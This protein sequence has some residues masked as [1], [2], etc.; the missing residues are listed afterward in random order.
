M[1][2]VELIKKKSQL[3]W[4]SRY[5]ICIDE[6]RIRSKSKKKKSKIRNPD[7]PIRMGWTVNK[8]ADQGENGNIR[9]A[10]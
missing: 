9:I 4:S 7:T 1:E 6:V 3:L 10:I 2:C 8:I 5:T